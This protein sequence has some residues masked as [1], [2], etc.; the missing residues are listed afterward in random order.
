MEKRRVL[1]LVRNLD[2]LCVESRIRELNEGGKI[3][4][5][6]K[7]V[8]HRSLSGGIVSSDSTSNAESRYNK[9]ISVV[10][11]NVSTE[12]ALFCCMNESTKEISG[13]RSESKGR[14]NFEKETDVESNNISTDEIEENELPETKTSEED[15]T[16]GEGEAKEQIED[17]SDGVS[18]D[19][20]FKQG[21]SPSST[22][23]SRVIFN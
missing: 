19:Y 14:N 13:V 5:I 3:R 6:T 2:N 18:V 9:D 8:R 20:E 1:G 4:R 15:E 16:E 7:S 10:T 12:K 17:S 22:L 11:K 21:S 23:S